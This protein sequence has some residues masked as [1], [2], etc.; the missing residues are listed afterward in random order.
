MELFAQLGH[1]PLIKSAVVEYDGVGVFECC[2]NCVSSRRVHASITIG[3]IFEAFFVCLAG[4]RREGR[5]YTDK[6]QKQGRGNPEVVVALAV[7]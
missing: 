6:E 1:D 3:C 4:K 7:P 2:F 5:E